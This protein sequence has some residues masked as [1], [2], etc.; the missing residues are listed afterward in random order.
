MKKITAAFLVLLVLGCSGWR[1][2]EMEAEEYPLKTGTVHIYQLK[3]FSSGD[4][5]VS[6]VIGTRRHSS[7]DRTLYVDSIAYFADDSFNYS[8]EEY[9][10]LSGNHL[11]YYGEEGSYLTE[12]IPLIAFPLYEGRF[13]YLDDEDTLGEYYECIEY[14]TIFLEPG[15]YRTFC[16]EH[17]NT[18]SSGLVRYWYAPD[19]GLVKFSHSIPHGESQF[20]ELLAYYPGGIPEDTTGDE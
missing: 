5:M 15:R 12:P 11:Y 16:I 8:I 6:T 18:G 1:G 17:S 2:P 20:K 14:D 7:S 19:V 10:Y 4:S 3:G 9:Y 13:W